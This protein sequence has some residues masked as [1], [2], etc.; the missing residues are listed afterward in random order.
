MLG[1]SDLAAFLPA[2]LGALSGAG[3]HLTSLTSH[4][5][6]LEDVFV[7]HTGRALRDA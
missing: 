2:L 4:E 6:T 1:I 3:A 5:P 7:Q